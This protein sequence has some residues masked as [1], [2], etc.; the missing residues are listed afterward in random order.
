MIDVLVN[1]VVF[2]I[3]LA[4]FIGM[5]FGWAYVMFGLGHEN[6]DR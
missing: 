2:G 6:T 4:L 3:Q 5:G 1:T